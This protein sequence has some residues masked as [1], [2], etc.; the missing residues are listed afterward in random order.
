[1]KGL[2][3][4]LLSGT[5]PP[6]TKILVPQ[7]EIRARE[8]NQHDESEALCGKMELAEGKKKHCP[9]CKL[10][11]GKMPQEVLIDDYSQRFQL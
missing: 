11:E 4:V 9:H 1:M 5:P 3:P 10:K 2:R 8:E 7:T 6:A